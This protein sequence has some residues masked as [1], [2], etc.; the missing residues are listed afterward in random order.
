MVCGSWL[1]IVCLARPVQNEI[2]VANDV[3]QALQKKS[4]KPS[5]GKSTGG[6][7]GNVVHVQLHN[8]HWIQLALK[9]D[10]VACQG[11]SSCNC[12]NVLNKSR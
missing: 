12:Y 10:F 9:S 2:I 5:R 7:L 3:H 4:Y 1:V 11:C 6:V 8:L